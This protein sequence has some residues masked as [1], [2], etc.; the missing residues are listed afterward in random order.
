M[1]KKRKFKWEKG[2]SL[3]EVLVGL[4]TA[5]LIMGAM[6]VA[7]VSALNNAEFSKNQ[8]SAVQYAQ[9]GVE[10]VRN[11]RDRD[12][13]LFSQLSGDYCLAKS[14][15]SLDPTSDNPQDPCGPKSI[16]CSQNVGGENADIFVRQVSV[17]QNGANAADCSDATQSN[18]QAAKVVVN[19]SWFDAKCGSSNIFCHTV[20]SST[21]LSTFNTISSQ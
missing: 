16:I 7:T 18:T 20:T 13:A 3:I 15:T 5:V 9:Q 11:L 1:D 21:C 6:T 8:H 17:Y 19:V 10:I 4:A 14:C 12:Y 2:Q